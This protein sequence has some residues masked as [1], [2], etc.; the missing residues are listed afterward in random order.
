MTYQNDSEPKDS[1]ETSIRL[2]GKSSELRSSYG[3]GNRTSR[4][5][6]LR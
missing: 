2:K 1:G 3:N 4:S 6:I 5:C